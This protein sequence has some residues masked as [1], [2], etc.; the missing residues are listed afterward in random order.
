MQV[1][2]KK[3]DEAAMDEMWSV[4]GHKDQQRWFWQAS[5]HQT[6]EVLAYVLGEHTDAVC[7]QWKKLRAPLHI[8]RFYTDDWGYQRHIPEA[9]HTIG[10]QNTQKI[11]RKHLT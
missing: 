4:V 7:L 5:D 11:E 8:T 6:G 9:Y 10:K 3:V 1:V 2:I